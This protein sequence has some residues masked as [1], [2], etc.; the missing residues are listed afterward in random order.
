MIDYK[1]ELCKLMAIV[2][3]GDA[4][5]QTIHR[6]Y[7]KEK[8]RMAINGSGIG[9]HQSLKPIVKILMEESK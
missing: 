8:I 4:E 1:E 7:V 6:S 2:M 3:Q 9:I 5:Q